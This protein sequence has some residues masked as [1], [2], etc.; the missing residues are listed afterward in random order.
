MPVMEI[1]LAKAVGLAPP[2][3]DTGNGIVLPNQA[4]SIAGMAAK[5][6]R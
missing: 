4:D 6:L 5:G 3:I 2:D 1:Y